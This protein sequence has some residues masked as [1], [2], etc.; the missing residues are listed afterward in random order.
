MRTITARLVAVALALGIAVAPAAAAPPQP[1][2]TAERPVIKTGFDLAVT[3]IRTLGPG[4]PCVYCPVVVV[5]NL[6]SKP[7]KGPFLLKYV[8]NGTVVYGQRSV[9]IDLAPGASQKIPPHMPLDQNFA[10]YGD[11][12]EAKIDADNQ[13][14]EDNE[15]NNTYREKLAPPVPRQPRK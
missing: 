4:D 14:K 13:L 3:D 6:G 2:G 9:V 1:G 15:L 5:K 8:C 7:V 12:V 11:N 10:R